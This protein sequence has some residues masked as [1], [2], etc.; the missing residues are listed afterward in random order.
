MAGIAGCLGDDDDGEDLTFTFEETF[1]DGLDDWEIEAAI[2]P[3]VDLEDWDWSIDLTDEPVHVGE[4]SIEV[5]TEG[6]YDDGLAWLATTIEIE[7]D[8][9]YHAEASVHAWSQ[10]YSD[11]NLRRLAC[12]LGPDTPESQ[13]DFPQADWTST[14]KDEPSYG[15]I[16]DPLNRAEG[17]H[18]HTFEW[19]S[20]RLS[21]NELTFA[22]GIGV[23]WETD[24]TYYLDDFEVILETR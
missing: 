24:L 3:E 18:E 1:D 13:T 4:Q 2:G 16:R 14:D 17:W 11:N 23:V 19:E 12:Y 10:S 15:G 9:R 22:V 21:T 8:R 7:P 5:F 6:R 20:P